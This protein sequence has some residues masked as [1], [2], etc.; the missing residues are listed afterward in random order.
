VIEA[1]V[2]GAIGA[3][4]LLVGA[5]LAFAVDVPT[6]VR[7]LILAFGAGALFGAVAYELFEEAVHVSLTGVD[8]LIGFA[9][10]AIVFFTGSVLIDRMGGAGSVTD[11]RTAGSPGMPRVSSRRDPRT[12]GLSV[13]LGTVLDGIPESVVLGASLIGGTG[14]G[15]PVLVAIAVSNVPE[16]L[17][18]TEDLSVAGFGRRRVL[19]IWL[20]VVAAS[21]LAAALGYAVLDA[22]GPSV[23][24][25]VDAFA[26]GAILT[27]LAETMIPE[28]SEIGG[29]AV[30]LATALGFAVAAS[31]SFVA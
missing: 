7:G 26:A 22:A 1:A 10:G 28:A 21:T 4:T 15:I 14:V 20:T 25:F 24:A 12:D 29:R 3:S 5:G 11:A 2:W 8:V 27:M 16:G 18:A 19:A 31:L 13:L 30:G 9:A 17:S 23:T 6:R